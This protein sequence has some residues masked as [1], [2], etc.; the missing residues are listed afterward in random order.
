MIGDLCDAYP[1]ELASLIDLNLIKEMSQDIKEYKLNKNTKEA[2]K[3]AES[4]SCLI[5]LFVLF[6]CQISLIFLCIF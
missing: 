3:F 1:R 6:L 4:V 5:K 2:I